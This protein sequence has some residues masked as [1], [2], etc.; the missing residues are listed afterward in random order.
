MGVWR[1]GRRQKHGGRESEGWLPVVGRSVAFW[2]WALAYSYV[3]SWFVSI[4]KPWRVEGVDA[5]GFL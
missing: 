5:Q 2:L 1:L 4:E 3:F